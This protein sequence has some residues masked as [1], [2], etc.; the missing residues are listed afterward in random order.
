MQKAQMQNAPAMMNP[1]EATHGGVDQLSI[2]AGM[3]T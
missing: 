2:R 1:T 3:R